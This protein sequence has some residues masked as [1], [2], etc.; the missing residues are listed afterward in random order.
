MQNVKLGP[1]P[2]LVKN[3]LIRFGIIDIRTV[4]EEQLINDNNSCSAE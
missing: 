3:K 4:V 1:L 2:G